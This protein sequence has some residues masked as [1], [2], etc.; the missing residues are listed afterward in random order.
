MIWILKHVDELTKLSS[1]YLCIMTFFSLLG[2]F[3][4]RRFS[5]LFSW[6]YACDL[7]RSVLL[8][9]IALLRSYLYARPPSFGVCDSFI[10]LVGCFVANFH[11][12]VWFQLDCLH[13]HLAWGSCEASSPPSLSDK[14]WNLCLREAMY[15]KAQSEWVQKVI[16]LSVNEKIFVCYWMRKEFLLVTSYAHNPTPSSAAFIAMLIISWSD[17][18]R[19]SSNKFLI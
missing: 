18:E 5:G 9:A 11:A 16:S 12:G 1:T 14:W 4:E 3:Y 17:V 13:A 19:S 8:L 6:C 2:G 15:Y 7:T 10:F